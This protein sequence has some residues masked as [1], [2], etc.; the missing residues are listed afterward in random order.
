MRKL[1]IEMGIYVGCLTEVKKQHITLALFVKTL[2][3]IINS[4]DQLGIAASIQMEALLFVTQSF[5]ISQMFR[6]I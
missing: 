6:Y 3:K 2:S 4:A 1:Q 5:I